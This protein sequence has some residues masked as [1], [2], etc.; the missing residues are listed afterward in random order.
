MIG[1]IHNQHQQQ[2]KLTRKEWHSIAIQKWRF[3]IL[4]QKARAEGRTPGNYLDF[5]LEKI[6]I[7]REREQQA[8]TGVGRQ[9]NN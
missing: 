9:S 3:N 6:G 2:E 4:A 1:K 8:T 7:G 5:L